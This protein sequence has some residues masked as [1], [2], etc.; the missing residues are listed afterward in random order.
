MR[1]F[2][3]L[4]VGTPAVRVYNVGN[5]VRGWGPGPRASYPG[6]AWR[7]DVYGSA[8]LPTPSR[9]GFLVPTGIIVQAPRASPTPPRQAE[10]IHLSPKL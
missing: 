4:L 3:L 6:T 5:P 8:G 7:G 10:N 9:P 2:V 1:S